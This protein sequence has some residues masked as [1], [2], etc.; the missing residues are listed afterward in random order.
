MF[1]RQVYWYSSTVVLGWSPYTLPPMIMEVKSGSLQSGGPS[2]S[3]YNIHFKCSHLPL[4][5]Q[6]EK[7]QWKTM[8]NIF[9]S[10]DTCS[11]CLF[12]DGWFLVAKNILGM[13]SHL[14]GARLPCP[15]KQ[16]VNG[17]Q[18]DGIIWCHGMCPTKIH[19][20]LEGLERL[21]C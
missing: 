6:Y 14:P 16:D 7:E 10:Y 4:P 5:W 1:W 18:Y 17:E 19:S 9:V 13:L 11:S 21:T 2:S 3:S 20:K 12:W 8:Q 15:L